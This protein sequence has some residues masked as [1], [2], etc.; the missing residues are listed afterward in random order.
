VIYRDEDMTKQDILSRASRV[1]YVVTYEEEEKN[2]PYYLIPVAVL[3][4][5]IGLALIVF[6]V[7]S[8]RKGPKVDE[9][10][11]PSRSRMPPPGRRSPPMR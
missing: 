4:F 6:Y 3:V 11:P 5:I 7:R 1:T 10:Q 8:I 9:E 2:V